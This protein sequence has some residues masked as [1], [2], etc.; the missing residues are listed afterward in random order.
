M[1]F[2]F[3][4]LTCQLVSLGNFNRSIPTENF[5]LNDKSNSVAELRNLLCESLKLRILNIPV[6][7]GLDHERNARVA[8]LFSGG[9]DC[10][11]LARLA[12]DI[13]PKDEDID[14]VNVA[15]ENPR[16]VVAASNMAKPKKVKEGGNE[17]ADVNRQFSTLNPRSAFENCP[18][19]QTGRKAFQELHNVCPDR[20]WRFVAVRCRVSLLAPLLTASIGQHPLHGDNGR[21]GECN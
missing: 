2:K 19:R 18:D 10:T 20:K 8:V 9:L 3:A 16:V 11:V 5:T 14:L 4:N 13:L 12:H 7:P 1:T 17:I 15:F 6:P 21:E